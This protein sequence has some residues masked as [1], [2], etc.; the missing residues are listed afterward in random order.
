M[1]AIAIP[2]DGH[3]PIRVQPVKCCGPRT[4]IDPADDKLAAQLGSIKCGI[5]S[6]G[7]I[8]IESKDDMRKRGLPSPNRAD[9]AAMI[10]SGRPNPAPMNVDSHGGEN[11]TRGSD[12]KGVVIAK[13]IGSLVVVSL[14]GQTQRAEIRTV[15]L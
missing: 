4:G 15:N 2:G 14:R 10:F 13:G 1:A 8:K 5:D 9:A 11:I 6:R 7:R 3:R 12:D